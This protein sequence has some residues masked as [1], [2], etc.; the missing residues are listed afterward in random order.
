M[1][2]LFTSLYDETYFKKEEQILSSE[3]SFYMKREAMNDLRVYVLFNGISVIS[4]RWEGDNER[5]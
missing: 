1:T 3:C 2:F 4:G 5:L